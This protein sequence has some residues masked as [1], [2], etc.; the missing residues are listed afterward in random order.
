MLDL[1]SRLHL[2][3]N[4]CALRFCVCGHA[5][6]LT[7]YIVHCSFS[8]TGIPGVK[9]NACQIFHLLYIIIHELSVISTR[10]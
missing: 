2:H 6:Y 5:L 9:I 4:F 1:Y 8:T 7:V 3:L 10:S